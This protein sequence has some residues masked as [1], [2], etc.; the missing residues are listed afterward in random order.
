M[1]DLANR[2]VF[3][4][5]GA[6]GIGFGIA[7]AFAAAGARIA[8]TDLDTERLAEAERDLAAE[9]GDRVAAYALD[10]RDRTAFAAAVDAA[11]DRFGP[12]AVIC[13]NAGLGS[14]AGTV[15]KLDYRQWDHVLDVN[16]GGVVNGVQ[17]VLPRMLERGGPGHVV[18]TA[19]G[20]GLV[21]TRN[22]TYVASKFAVVGI[23]ESL[24]LQP[25]L[26][27]AGIGATVLC[28]G[29]VRTDVLRN[30]ARA[31]GVDG[32]ELAEQGHRL[33]Q[34]A[35]LEPDQVGEQVLAAVRE[36]ELYV[37]TDRY[38]LPLLE[39]RMRL[40]LDAFPPET[41][42]DRHLA[43]QL[44]ARQPTLTPPIVGADR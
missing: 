2:H 8:L 13:N 21:G 7:R 23:T 40:L 36:G 22:L 28:P 12:V 33:L 37:H 4:T 5:G 43:A 25:E 39:Q 26:A 30:S 10:V 32:S 18:N 17:T 16:L 44:E 29:I 31:E 41:E 19:S 9:A 15:T 42:R 14:V 20:A 35:G 6:Q 1:R 11:E 38:I 24:R 34:E 27:A 3:I